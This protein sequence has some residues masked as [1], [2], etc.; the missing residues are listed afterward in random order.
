MTHFKSSKA[1]W[2]KVV[3]LKGTF[4]D[5][6]NVKGGNKWECCGHTDASDLQLG[7]VISQNNKPIAFYSCKL[8]STQH[9][10]TVG[11]K[12]LLSIVE[13]LKEFCN[14]L[15]GHEIN[16]FTDHKN[17]I[18]KDHNNYFCEMSASSCK[19]LASVWMSKGLLKSE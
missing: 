1:Y 9:N 5:I 7:A 3:H 17:L 13:V 8:N 18:Y 6:I 14:I 19:S 2:C 15:L 4:F 12:E 10:Y 16:V 11:E